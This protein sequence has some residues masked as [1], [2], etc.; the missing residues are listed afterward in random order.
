MQIM[1]S[2]LLQLDPFLIFPFR[3]TEISLLGFYIGTFALALNCVLLGRLTIQGIMRLNRAYYGKLEKETVRMHNLSVK[4]ILAKDKESYR[5]CNKGANEAFG[6]YFFSQIAM[7]A[8]LLWPIPFALQW[9]STRFQGISFPLPFGTASLNYAAVFIL[10]YI[11]ARILFSKNY[12]YLP[13]IFAGC[14]A[15]CRK[16]EDMIQWSDIGK[17]KENLPQTHSPVRENLEDADKRNYIPLSGLK[18]GT[19]ENFNGNFFRTACKAV[20]PSVC[21]TD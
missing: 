3:I 16:K 5:A 10:L 13:P 6:K 8:S 1:D 4:A 21:Q 12:A 9:M 7:G 11:Q 19:E 15:I 17:K 20:A 18:Q 14:S 2:F